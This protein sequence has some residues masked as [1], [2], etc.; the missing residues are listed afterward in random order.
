MVTLTGD[1]NA[2]K[3]LKFAAVIHWETLPKV[4]HEAGTKRFVVLYNE[5]VVNVNQNPKNE[6]VLCIGE[7]ARVDSG[8]H[9]TP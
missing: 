8:T 6:L 4:G 9:K 7:E 1:G 2:Q 5:A 3:P